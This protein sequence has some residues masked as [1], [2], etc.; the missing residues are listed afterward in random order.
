[1]HFL[2][3]SGEF[4]GLAEL[5]RLC[6]GTPLNKDEQW[7]N[8]E[9]RPLRDTQILYA[10]T[11][12]YCLLEVYDLMKIRCEEKMI[13]LQKVVHTYFKGIASNAAKATGSH[14]KD[15]KQSSSDMVRTVTNLPRHLSKKIGSPFTAVT[16]ASTV[17]L[18]VDNML[19][20]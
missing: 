2:I 12:A 5:V 16:P 3:L 1:M 4:K 11:D 17:K 14:K 18:V 9:K 19:A 20:G 6:T 15:K 10:A 8:W 13:D 7:S